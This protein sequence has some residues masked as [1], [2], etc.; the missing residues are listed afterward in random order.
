M[1]DKSGDEIVSGVLPVPPEV[2]VPE[3][4][5]PSRARWMEPGFVCRTFLGREVPHG[6]CS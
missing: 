1:T 4:L 5:M 2:Q 3:A 6:C